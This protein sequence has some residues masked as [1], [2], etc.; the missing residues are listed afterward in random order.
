MLN[1]NEH[2]ILNAHK[3]KNIEKFS[4]FSGSDQPRIIL[5][6]FETGLCRVKNYVTRS[7]LGKNLYTLEGTVL[8]QTS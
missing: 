6:K 7:D 8:I 3:C 5:T 4:F 1:S 2:E